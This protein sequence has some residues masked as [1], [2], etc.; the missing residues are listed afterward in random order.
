M[1]A[2]G[3]LSRF[4]PL[5]NAERLG[6]GLT[7]A[8]MAVPE[9]RFDAVAAQVN[10]FPEVAHNYRREHR[11][12]MWFVLATAEPGRID[13]VIREI[14]RRTGLAVLN[15]PRE[16]EYYLGLQLRLGAG[17][18]G[19][20]LA[21][22]PGSGPATPPDTTD[23]EL[24]RATQA[25]LP[26]VAE[27]W[28]AVAA[29]TGIAER[30]VLERFRA[31]LGRGAI[32]RIGVVP[33]HYRLGFT[34]NGMVVWDVEDGALP[35]LGPRIGALP[36]VSHCY[37]RPRRLPEWPYNLFTMVHGRDRSQVEA[38]AAAIRAL[39]GEALREHRILLSRGILK[40]TGLRL[41]AGAGSTTTARAGCAA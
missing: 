38:R 24:V 8:A 4:G 32:R 18:A 26:L 33:N 20:G 1:L 12:N 9:E 29:A 14:R 37:R 30:E 41:P 27:P 16:E 21:R 17:E 13:E 39:L 40:K 31:M 11:F 5:Y 25:G 23:L 7:L 15:L 35:A 34:A 10:A 2:S 3:L 28:A 6:G 22:D 19:G 36:F